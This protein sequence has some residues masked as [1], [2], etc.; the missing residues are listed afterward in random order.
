M[1]TPDEKKPEP[2]PNSYEIIVDK[3]AIHEEFKRSLIRKT[4]RVKSILP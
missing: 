1:S 3:Q 4:K 2:K